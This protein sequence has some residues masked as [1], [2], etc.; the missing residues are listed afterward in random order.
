MQQFVRSGLDEARLFGPPS[1]LPEALAQAGQAGDV[2][3]CRERDNSVRWRPGERLHHLFEQRCDQFASA[4][5]MRHLAVDSAEGA[6]TYGELDVRAN[7]LAR[8]LGAQGLRAGD[9]VALLFDKSVHSYVSMLAV[10][11]IHAA[12][13]PLDPCFPADRIAFIASDAGVRAIL[14]TSEHRPLVEGAGPTVLCVDEASAAIDVQPGSR[15][16]EADAGKPAGELCYIIYTS[17]S[18]GRPKGVPIEHASICNFVRVAAEVYGYKSTDRVYQGLTIAFDFAVEEIWVPLVVGATLLPNQTGSSL[19]GGDLAAFLRSRKATAM[20]CVPTLLATIDETLPDLRLLIVSGEA[21][22]RDLI[23]RWDHPQRTILNAYGPT[24]STVTATLARPRPNE[25]VTIGRPLPTYSIVIL[26]PG[27]EQALPFGET[28]EIGIAGIGV[29]Q[30]YLNREEQTRQAFIRDFLGIPNNPSG[31]IYRTGDLGRV[32]ERGELEYL[33]RIDTQV[34]IRGYRIE[35]SE[36]ESVILGLPQVA[37]AVVSTFE[38]TPGVKEL[39]AYYA[40]KADTPPLSAEDMARDLRSLLPSYMVPAFYEQLPAI[41]LLASD[42]A[43]RKALPAPSGTRM[44]AG[45]REFVEPQGALETDIAGVLARL[46]QLE[47]V[48]VDDHF[49]DDLGANSLLMAQFGARL[50]SELGIADF[51]M[52]E[53]YLYPS[54]RKLSAFLAAVVQK[55]A[56]LRR[57]TPAHVATYRQYGLCAVLQLGLAFGVIYLD[58]FLLWE[59]YEWIIEARGL[60]AAYVRAVAFS[61]AAF[62]L[63]VGLPV[64]LKWIL[65]GRWKPDEFP[66]WSLK[67]LRFWTVK[68]LVRINPMA[69]FAGTPLYIGYLRLLGA[70]VSWKC[71]IFSPQVPVCTDLVSIGPGAVISKSVAFSGYRAEA[72]RIRTGSITLGRDTFVG[73]ATVLDVDTVMEAGSELAHASS[74]HA[75]QRLAAGACY[76]GAPAQPAESRCRR[77]ESGPVSVTRMVLYSLAQLASLF[78][79]YAPLPFLIAHYFFGADRDSASL[80]IAEAIGE[81]AALA[82]LPV[83]LSWTSLLFAAF[84]LT[85]LAAVIALPRL[86]NVFVKA[87]RVYPLYGLHFFIERGVAGRSNSKLYNVLF[88]D[89]S[90]I[91]Y[92]LK[93]IGYRFKDGFEQTGTNF[94]QSQQHDNPFLCEIGRGTMASDGLMML[95]TEYSASSFRVSKVSIGAHNFLGNAIAF[96]PDAKAGDNCLLG[97]KV[98]LP[99]DGARREN[100]GLLGSPCFEIPRSVRRDARFDR[101]KQ[102]DVLRQ[103]LKRKNAS[104]LLT[105]GLFLLAHCTALNVV[106]VTWYYTYHA[107]AMHGPLYL[108]VLSIVM[109]AALTPYYILVDWASLGFRPLQPQ[110]CSIY[111]GYFW[112]HER[113]WKLG[114]SNDQFLLGMLNGTP[115]KALAWRALGVHVGK[116]LFDDGCSIPEKTLVAIGDHCTLGEQ[117]T[118]QAHS[119]EDGTFKSDRIVIGN[120]CTVGAHCWVHYG[121]HMEDQASLEPDAFLMKGEHPEARSSWRGN[122]AKEMLA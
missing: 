81:P 92:Y 121:V 43:D 122:P 56:P 60:Q 90:F 114:L 117:S 39:V 5:D 82:H 6:W 78:L 50:R 96:P 42:K 70:R 25:P 9:I 99:T 110:Y 108:A 57:D 4:G 93:A 36:I 23:E 87:D 66:V 67:Y 86:L 40:L 94:G 100:V 26:V 28:G 12:Y 104:N 91:V 101:Y 120:G 21:C 112:K 52:R 35:L 34:K 16:D 58:V 63:T 24:E 17:G 83:L 64:A 33:G 102:K 84:L 38:P 105:I 14:T 73:E 109:L 62:A 3:V 77:L 115:F 71:V 118:L 119:L 44:N 97:T 53:I 116:K 27:A 20:C 8:Y 111:D 72:G 1:L 18:T 55:R 61:A 19:L 98:M 59:G 30:G 68:Q 106:S 80:T 107:F 69:G 49:F 65:V 2:L 48:S 29:A 75:G 37:Q 95:N 113:Y 45:G 31:R 85:G 88:G 51:S 22:P 41:P 74:L 103:R 15:L 13:V 89:S 79:L 47:R 10:L 46:L 54:V 76:H 7:R 32:N 11:K